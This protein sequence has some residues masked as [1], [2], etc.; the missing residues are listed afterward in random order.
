MPP[1]AQKHEPI[2]AAGGLQRHAHR[3]G[4]A[5]RI[6]ERVRPLEAERVQEAQHRLGEVAE[7]VLAV[8]PLRRAAEARQV[9]H[10]QA[11]MAGERGEIAGEVRDA[12]RAG[13]AAMQQQQRRPL[14]DF[15]DVDVAGADANDPPVRR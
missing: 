7:R 1:G 5:E 11:E 12:R 15:D 3:A 2:D 6:A 9:G 8:E 14:S 13:A 4:A 10:D